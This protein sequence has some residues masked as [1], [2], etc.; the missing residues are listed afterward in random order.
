MI[1]EDSKGDVFTTHNSDRYF[2]SPGIKKPQLNLGMNG[3]YSDW[4]Y[5]CAELSLNQFAFIILK[6][7]DDG[8]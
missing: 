8:V 7:F 6:S 1:T 3:A 5:L 4:K 2:H